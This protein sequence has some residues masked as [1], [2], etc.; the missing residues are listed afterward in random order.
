MLFDDQESSQKA[1]SKILIVDTSYLI[2]RSFFAY[3]KLTYGGESVG[4][5]FGFCKTIISLV[6]EFGI[7]ELV[8]AVDLPKPTFRHIKY[9][10]YKAGRPETDP[11]MKKQFPIIYEWC[12]QVSGN[13]FALEGFEAD[14]M[15]FS[16]VLDTLFPTSK[17]V[18]SELHLDKLIKTTPQS[19]SQILI[20]SADKDLYQTLL[21]PHV[22]FI[23]NEKFR[24]YL[25][26]QN[27]F[28]TEFGLSPI[29]WIDYKALVGDNSDNLKGI[30]GVGP[31]T[32]IKLLQNV[33][34]LHLLLDELGLQNG[35]AFRS[36][37]EPNDQQ[38]SKLKSFV[39]DKSNQTL[40]Q[41]IRD[42]LEILQETYELA[43]LHYVPDLGLKTGFDLSL[44]LKTFEKFGFTSLAKLVTKQQDA[45]IANIQKELQESLF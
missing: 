9:D 6:A 38:K 7:T 36:Y 20:F 13:F 39:E 3:P 24:Y 41:K 12:N 30:A 40:I 33:G 27:S 4:A 8:F 11:E 26:D 45:K 29:Q 15:I 14:D 16:K 34:N 32:A 18:T 2:F 37:F 43:S 28:E 17:L 22:K 31:K 23:R 25:Y 21:F 1:D 10:A 35:F 5:V 44:G 42:N 19:E